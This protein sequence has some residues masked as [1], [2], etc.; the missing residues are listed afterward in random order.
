MRGASVLLLGL[1]P[2]RLKSETL[3]Y[4]GFVKGGGA[5]GGCGAD[6]FVRVG[7]ESREDGGVVVFDGEV[8]GWVAA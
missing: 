1:N 8:D 2:T 6:F 5:A 7:E 3:V 4:A